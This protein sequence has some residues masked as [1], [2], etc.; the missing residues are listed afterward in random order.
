M[1]AFGYVPVPNLVMPGAHD[2][3]A[4]DLNFLSTAPDWKAAR[5]LLPL[6]CVVKPWSE[7]QGCDAAGQLLAGCRYF[8]LRIGIDDAAGEGTAES[9][10]LCH[11]YFSRGTLEDFL[12]DVRGFLDEHP[13]EAVFLEVKTVASFA[14]SVS[15]EQHH[16]LIAYT[17][18]LLGGKG[19]F[20]DKTNMMRPLGELLSEGKQVFMVYQPGG[21]GH[22]GESP[23]DEH[24]DTMLPGY[25]MRS[26]WPNVCDP[27]SL[28]D[29]LGQEIEEQG[30]PHHDKFLVLQCVMTPGANEIL[31]GLFG[32]G[33]FDRSLFAL[34]RRAEPDLQEMLESVPESTLAHGAV[35][36]LDWLE[37]QP[38]LVQWVL[39]RNYVCHAR[40]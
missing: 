35:I 14:D 25:L 4:Q 31:K 20:V 11:G 7:A 8:D 24:R 18:E 28:C 27:T 29:C 36:M 3:G 10:R 23:V 6:A 17:E 33:F 38:D 9:Y 1:A 21:W 2:S 39:Q 12:E 19:A 26:M 37:E 30:A 32:C 34:A 13:T 16:A 22:P 5:G 15:M 40:S